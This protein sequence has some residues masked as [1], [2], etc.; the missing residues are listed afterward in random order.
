MT[1][2]W[3]DTMTDTTT[4][5]ATD[6][7]RALIADDSYAMTFQSMGQ[8]RTALLREFDAARRAQ[9]RAELADERKMAMQAYTV[10]AFD[11]KANPVGSRDWTL[12]WA[13]WITSSRYR[14]PA[15]GTTTLSDAERAFVELVKAN[16]GCKVNDAQAFDD[17]GNALWR[18]P[19]ALGLIECVG[20]YEWRDAVTHATHQEGSAS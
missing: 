10:D 3:T 5:A 16:P 2:T 15:T 7:L 13:G 17:A 8:Y 14:A 9:P 6:K 1:K 4:Q 12:Y 11:Y 20:S 19:E 18:K